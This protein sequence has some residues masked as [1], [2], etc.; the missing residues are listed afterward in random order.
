MEGQQQLGRQVGAQAV[1]ALLALVIDPLAG[2]VRDQAVAE[3]RE[4]VLGLDARQL[5][6]GHLLRVDQVLVVGG[7]DRRVALA[8]RLHDARARGGEARAAERE[9]APVREREGVD[10][11]QEEVVA[12]REQVEVE[13]APADEGREVV[14]GEREA[15]L[16]DVGGGAVRLERALGVAADVLVVVGG[17][18]GAARLARE[19][20]AVLADQA[21]ARGGC[22]VGRDGGG[23]ALADRPEERLLVLEAAPVRVADARDEEAALALRVGREDE[24]GEVEDGHVLHAEGHVAHDALAL[25]RDVRPPTGDAPRRRFE[26]AA[27]AGGEDAVRDAVPGAAPLVEAGGAQEV[28]ARVHVGGGVLDRARLVVEVEMREIALRRGLRI[29]E[30]DVSARLGDLVGAVE[31]HLVG[32]E[33]GVAARERHAAARGERVARLVVGERLRV[34]RD[35]V[36]AR[37]RRLLDPRAA[38][39]GD[40]HDSERTGLGAHLDSDLAERRGARHA[41]GD[42]LAHE[43]RDGRAAGLG[44]EAHGA[45]HRIGDLDGGGARDGEAEEEERDVP[46]EGLALAR[47]AARR[48]RRLG[49]RRAVLD[50][51]P[52][53]RGDGHRRGRPRPREDPDLRRRR[54][55]QEREAE[56]ESAHAW[57]TGSGGIG[58]AQRAQRASS[59]RAPRIV[60]QAEHDMT[61]VPHRPPGPHEAASVASAPGG[62]QGS[63]S[64]RGPPSSA[65]ASPARKS[66]PVTSTAPPAPVRASAARSAAR[67]SSTA[68]AGTRPRS[69]AASACG[70]AA[71]RPTR[72]TITPAACARSGASIARQSLSAITANTSSTRRSPTTPGSSAASVAAP[73]GLWAPSTTTSGRSQSTASRPGQRT[74]ARPASTASGA[75]G[76]RSRTSASAVRATAALSRWKAPGSARLKWS[77]LAPGPRKASP[78]GASPSVA[79]VPTRATGAPTS[80]ARASTTRAASSGSRPSASGTPAFRMPAFSA[81]IAARSCPSQAS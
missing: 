75:H 44:E 22:R 46:G 81:A 71:R 19:H 20:V 38:L 24:V 51:D 74:A 34:H 77:Q 73:A 2:Q 36:L 18:E 13:L 39:R 57:P 60:E 21:D 7:L 65:Y 27:L 6:Q 67:G 31:D 49:A 17:G 76:K 43:H 50:R 53:L 14:P 68:R 26:T 62:C 56:R 42:R 33:R 40:A 16:G 78:P 8:P 10:L 29:A 48:P 61:R 47:R 66:E 25:Q 72:V 30:D 23:G 4:G 37:R 35:L 80:A 5:L 9:V 55:E 41:V 12:H 45:H 3:E 54:R 52:G 79:S 69:A 64:A 1:V 70:S 15:V 63:K 59:G 28:V 11:A 32:G 58:A